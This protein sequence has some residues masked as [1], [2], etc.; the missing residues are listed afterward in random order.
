MNE[1]S[2]ASDPSTP[3][4][5]RRA[6]P[7]CGS[8]AT[9]F[10]A[11]LPDHQSRESFRLERCSDCQGRFINPPPPVEKIGRYYEGLGGAMMH[12][13]ENAIFAKLRSFA[14]ARELA[15]LLRRLPADAC[16]ADVGAGDGQ[17]AAFLAKKKYRTRALDTFPESGW[18]HPDVP[19]QQID[20]NAPDP[21]LFSP[22]DAVV[23]RH[24][25]EH[26]HEPATVLRTY[27]KAGVKFL[28]ILVPNAETR[29]ARAFGRWWYYMD[30]P[31]HLTFFTGATLA[32][33]AKSCG[34]RQV[35]AADH[36]IDELVTSL[37][38]FRMAAW[39]RRTDES[40]RR[41]LPFWFH[42]LKPKGI[43]AALSSV[44]SAPL[45]STVLCRVFELDS[46]P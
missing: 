15:P 11:D 46:A 16:I 26:V 17:V 19:Y 30:P 12:A 40:G 1:S 20:M 2:I 37:Y 36:G 27:A 39:A 44:L 24:V 32:K 5:A 14:I 28:F 7:L 3:L 8:S 25:L 35:E 38:R 34:Y 43:P 22:V 29:L 41:S 23:M 33:M 6:C 4:A 18:A 31:R 9:T 21:A 45:A 10:E 42:L 13:E